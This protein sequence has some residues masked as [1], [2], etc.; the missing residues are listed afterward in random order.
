MPIKRGKKQK[1]KKKKAFLKAVDDFVTS[2]T[3]EKFDVLIRICEEA[4][5]RFL[6]ELLDKY[7]CS[8]EQMIEILVSKHPAFA[9]A[10]F[11]AVLKKNTLAAVLLSKSHELFQALADDWEHPEEI[12]DKEAKVKKAFETIKKK[13]VIK[14]IIENVNNINVVTISL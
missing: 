13:D 5:E 9:L 3:E 8:N 6:I 12:T 10:R 4:K 1:K 14:A 2:N 11:C 7:Q